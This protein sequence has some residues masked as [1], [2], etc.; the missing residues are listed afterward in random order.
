MPE[1]TSLENCPVCNEPYLQDKRPSEQ[2]ADAHMFDCKRC[3][4]FRCNNTYL[5]S[6]NFIKYRHLVSAWIRRENDMGIYVFCKWK[7]PTFAKYFPRRQWG[8]LS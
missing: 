6:A 5:R 1:S 4:K 2:Y 8:K 3:G 7:I